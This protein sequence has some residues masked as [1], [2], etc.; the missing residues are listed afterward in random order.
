MNKIV[1]KTKLIF[2]PFVCEKQIVQW[3][4]QFFHGE[5]EVSDFLNVLQVGLFSK[6]VLHFVPIV[7]SCMSLGLFFV[8]LLSAE[9][10]AAQ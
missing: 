7:V 10:A 9:S 3:E 5:I 2:L 1:D 6:N 4:K 8:Q